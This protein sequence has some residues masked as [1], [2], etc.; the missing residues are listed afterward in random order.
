MDLPPLSSKVYIS[1]LTTSVD[2][3]T[4]RSKS[5]V[6]SN[7]GNSINEYPASLAGAINASRTYSNTLERGG[8][9]SLT[10]LGA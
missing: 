5:S 3:P 2:S 9:Y 4:P 10:P 1:L 6:S 7:T 8:K